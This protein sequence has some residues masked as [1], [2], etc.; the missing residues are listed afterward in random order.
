MADGQAR[1]LATLRV[2]GALEGSPAVGLGTMRL[3]DAAHRA[4]VD[5][6]LGRY[7]LGSPVRRLARRA[8]KRKTTTW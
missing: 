4:G 6:H 3:P 7:Y 5:A 2:V 8:G 1:T